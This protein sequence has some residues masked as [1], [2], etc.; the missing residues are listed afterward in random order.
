MES[1]LFQDVLILLGFSVMIV[2][3]LQKLKLP[4]ILGFLITGIIIGPYGLSLVTAVHQ[5]EI[6]AE[7]GVILLLFVIGLE[8]SIKQL[9]LIKKTVFIGGLLQ[10]SLTVGIAALAANVFG[11][12][13]DKAVFMGFLVSLSSTAIVLKVLQDKNEIS[14]AHGRNA[15]GILIF[16]DIIVVP[17]MLVTPIMAGNSDDITGSIIGLLVKSLIVVAITYVL[18]RY[19]VPKLMYLVAK[20]RSK[21]L[22]IL[23]TIT[24]CFAV[25]YLTS[26]AGLSLAL[27]AFLA[28]LIISESEYSHQATSI[29]L[30]FRELFTSFF[31]ISVGMLLNIGFFVENVSMV[32]LLVVGVMVLKTLA[33]AIAVVVLKYPIKTVLLTALALSQVGEFAFI[34]ATIGMDNNLLNDNVYQY[35][36]AISICSMLL[37]PFVI[38]YSEQMSNF[39]IRI[40]LS[41]KSKTKNTVQPEPVDDSLVLKNHL[42]IVGF[43]ING[44]SLAKAAEFSNIP[45]VVLELNAET[46]REEAEKGVPIIFGDA[47]DD[48]ILNH[49]DVFHARAIV[50][51]VTEL[52]TSKDIVRAVRNITQ[53]IY[54]L[55]R[56]K[57]VREINDLKAIGADEVIPE[58]LEAAVEIFSRILHNFLVPEDEITNFLDSIRSDNYNLFQDKAKVPRTFKSDQVPDFNITCLRVYKDSGSPVGRSLKDLDLRSKYNINVI[59]VARDGV[60]VSNIGAD[61]KILQND[62]LYVQGGV[63]EIEGFRKAIG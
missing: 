2:F 22:F 63:S 17:M 37:T 3:L 30:P 25:A 48:H 34:L 35:F 27:G 49:V 40:F 50:V 28:G 23:T 10:V 39:L 32:L 6:F 55:V 31:F 60:M 43:G 11:A 8:L 12:S 61:E 56:T 21:E 16:Q 45:Y 59:A 26:M 53:S 7:I 58:E 19:V 62:L 24:I 13:W 1:T 18:A 20:T 29:I 44:R 41:G 5:V 52:K 38:I 51:A 36:L 47:A 9:I 57:Y 54:L 4:S 46:V 33:T 15:L 42:I 14:A